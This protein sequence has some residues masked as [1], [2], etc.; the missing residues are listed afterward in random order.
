MEELTFPGTQA[1]VTIFGRSRFY[2]MPI[3]LANQWELR[4]S[5]EIIWK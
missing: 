5:E 2:A 3:G 1:Y 4:N